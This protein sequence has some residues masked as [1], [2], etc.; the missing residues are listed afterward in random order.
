M[1]VGAIASIGP[2]PLHGRRRTGNW[3]NRATYGESPWY[4][5]ICGKWK[6]KATGEHVEL[7]EM[8]LAEFLKEE[9]KDE[10]I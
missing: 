1:S 10:K 5:C 2:N 4:K 3:S 8:T 7:K 9:C 6:S